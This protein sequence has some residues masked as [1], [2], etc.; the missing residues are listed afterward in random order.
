VVDKDVI[1][2]GALVVDHDGLWEC[3]NPLPPDSSATGER[4]CSNC[5]EARKPKKIVRMF[6]Q[7]LPMGLSLCFC[8]GQKQ[9]GK[10]WRYPDPDRIYEILRAAKAPQEDHHAVA[11]ALRHR[12][13]GAIDLHLTEKQ[14]EKLKRGR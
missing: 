14:Y 7:E 5:L 4:L 2:N 3:K 11:E 6:Y 9:I 12:Q 10:H 1:G 13:P 8:E